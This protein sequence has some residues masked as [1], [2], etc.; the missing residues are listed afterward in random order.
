[1]A[2]HINLPAL[3]YGLHDDLQT[4]LGITQR[5]ISHPTAKGDAAELQWIDM[6]DDYLPNRYRVNKAFVIDSEG[7]CSDQI[8]VVIHDRQYSPFLLKHAGA[9]Y[10][11]AESVYAVFEVK[12]NLTA[13]HI[14]YA[15]DKVASVRRLHRT[16]LPIPHAGGIYKAKP[17]QPILGGILCLETDWTPP[18]GDAFRRAVLSKTGDHKLDLGCAIRNGAFELIESDGGG[19][20]LGVH[21]HG[22]ALVY[23][24]LRLIARLQTMATIPLLDVMAYAR[25]LDADKAIA[26]DGTASDNDSTK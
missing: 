18:F 2:Q 12:Q 17:P 16:S 10:V 20:G 25:W 24:F 5:V 3:L 7:C 1:M 15:G 14:A 23:F 22:N 13:E 6:L 9:R 8:D 4:R 21:D 19:R 11:P 26:E